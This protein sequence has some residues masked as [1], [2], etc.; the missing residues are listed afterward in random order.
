MVST[1][2][3][4]S[5]TK[6]GRKIVLCLPMGG[7]ND[8]LCQVSKCIEYAARNDRDLFIDTRLSGGLQI[9][10][11]QCFKLLKSFSVNIK[12]LDRSYDGDEI[13]K[14]I[15][16]DHGNSL[17]KILDHIQVSTSGGAAKYQNKCLTFDFS[18]EYSDPLLIHASDGGGWSSYRLLHLLTLR[19]TIRKAVK[20][21]FKNLPKNYISIHVRDT[22]YSSDYELFIRQIRGLI[23]ASSCLFISS[24]NP[25]AVAHVQTVFGKDRVWTIPSPSS[26]HV[27]LDSNSP[28]HSRELYLNEKSRFDFS[29]KCIIDLLLLANGEKIFF[30]RLGNGMYSG[31][32]VLALHLNKHKYL[33]TQLIEGNIKNALMSRIIHSSYQSSLIEKLQFNA[34]RLMPNHYKKAL[35]TPATSGYLGL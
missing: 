3:F 31:F 12:N 11:F 5:L 29:I 26:I 24:D 13:K 28:L 18:R 25:K 1:S 16:I 19:T 30:P 27:N 8:T 15:S 23:S 4:T 21:A 32:S 2:T 35:I 20:Q 34:Y 6:R 10:F 14:L 22:D 7:L 33:I 9:D 17:E